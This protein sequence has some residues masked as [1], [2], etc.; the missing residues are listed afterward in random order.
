MYRRVHNERS[1][2]FRVEKRGLFGWNFV[3]D[4]RSGDYLDFGERQQAHDWICDHTR[5]SGKQRRWQVVRDCRS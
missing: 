4:P 3:T 2:R 1:G 5:T